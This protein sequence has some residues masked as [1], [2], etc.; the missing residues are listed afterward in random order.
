MYQQGR[1]YR[2]YLIIDGDG[3]NC[4]IL[5]ASDSLCDELGLDRSDLVGRSPADVLPDG[6][7]FD[8]LPMG[9]GRRM[10]IL[11]PNELLDSELRRANFELE[12]ALQAAQAANQAKVSFLSNMS[13]DIRT[14][15][16][17]IIGMT[18]IAQNHIDER[19]RVQDCLD[20]IQTASSHLMSLI[21]DV[22]DMSRID[23]GRVTISEERFSLADLVHD[24]FVLLR[25]LADAKGHKLTIDVED[26]YREAL[27]GDALYLRQ[28]FVNIIGNSIK[29]TPD[30]GE[31]AVRFGETPHPTDPL[32][33]TMNFSCTD[34]GVGMSDDFLKRLGTPFERE[35]NSTLSG[36]E[37]TGLGMAITKSLIQQMGG[38]MKVESKL[39]EGS[40]FTVDIPISVSSA[41]EDYPSLAGM[42]V[43]LIDLDGAD[44]TARYLAESDAA[45]TTVGGGIQ[46]VSEIS[47]AQMEHR[48]F[49]AVLID[50]NMEESDLL[51]L[52]AYLR[53]Q[54]GD[55][56]PL[57]LVSDR[58]WG[59][60]EY[61]ATR[62]GLTGFIPRPL[63]KGR[64][65]RAL[66]AGAQ[67]DDSAAEEADF[68]GMRILLVEDNELNRE[69][70]VELIG[71][72]GAT[73]DAAED[74]S[75]ALEMFKASEPGTYHL[76][77]M[78]IQMPIMDGYEATRAIRALDRP[79]A[80]TVT[81]A[82]MTANAFVEDI[83]KTRDAGMDEHLSKPVDIS[84][85]EQLMRRCYNK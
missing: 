40:T 15:M 5:S 70:A 38:V 77:L 34:N 7:R 47:I 39:G 50:G 68:R 35:K 53:N 42:R 84:S 49:E 28:V 19:S 83:K 17:A 67:T 71:A 32:S 33:L 24:L 26:I 56:V 79:D 20:K 37:G 13:H 73:I 36:V 45:T 85:V 76:I 46:A 82:A 69:I 6:A 48:A 12:Q 25:P 58:D 78:D 51:D 27:M 18:N 11:S 41:T 8:T 55:G 54:L 61:A 57:L 16:N 30:G 22:L 65:I 63:F 10:L 29:Y 3:E 4:R 74:G 9:D 44:S 64:L 81:I 80:A 2:A 23:S 75:K 62:A 59:H 1:E 52:A 31:I 14:P 72:T 60:M 43:L 66:A 21:N